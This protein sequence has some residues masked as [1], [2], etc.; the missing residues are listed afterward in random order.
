MINLKVL[1][2]TILAAMLCLLTT[3]VLADSTNN[4]LYQTTFSENPKWTTNNPSSDYWDSSKGMYHFG[5]EPSTQGYA[6][7]PTFTYDGGPFTYEYDLILNQVDDGAALRLGF[8][9]ASMDLSQGPNVLTEFP[10]G[11][12]GQIMALTVITQSSK[13]EEVDSY[14]GS[15]R[16]PT[17]RYELNKTYHVVVTYSNDTNTVTETVTD[18][19][20]GQQVWS[21]YVNTR[22]SLHGMNRIYLGSKGD[23]GS[24]GVHAIGYID[25]V[26]VYT[27]ST[28]V[29]TTT[30][31]TI[32]TTALPTY[33]VSRSTTKT[34]TIAVPTHMPTTTQQSPASGGVT[35][36]ALGIMGAGG[37]LGICK[38]R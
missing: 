9:D 4:V 11:K 8:S 20:S 16:G 32:P 26:R 23:Y 36:A 5:I 17:V 1:L 37:A 21:Y 29:T 18:K 10:N 34:T 6:Y 12:Y 31:T 2:I 33:N 25:N 22:E 3:S 7:S 15:Y 28:E 24:M 27:P 13:L 35:I 38:K 19:L 30:V 14:T